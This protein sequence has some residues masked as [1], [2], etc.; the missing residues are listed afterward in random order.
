MVIVQ[1]PTSSNSEIKDF[2]YQFLRLGDEGFWC[3]EIL[4]PPSIHSPIDT[5]IERILSRSRL[6]DC[7]DSFAKLIGYESRESLLGK[8]PNQIPHFRDILD[9]DVLRNFIKS[10]YR[11]IFEKSLPSSDGYLSKHI[12]NSAYGILNRETITHICGS[13]VNL[14]N[15]KEIQFT[16]EKT[17]EFEKLISSISRSFISMNKDSLDS[18]IDKCLHQLGDFT[19]VD[20]SYVFLLSEDKTK[21]SNT[22]E[23]CRQGISSH[24][25]E[26]KD[27]NYNVSLSHTWNCIVEKNVYWA[28]S[29]E[30]MSSMTQEEMN[31][32]Y[33]QGIQSILLVGIRKDGSLLGFVG[34]DS[35][36]QT[37]KWNEDD[38]SM[39][40]IFSD[41]LSFSI[42]NHYFQE[43]LIKKEESLSDFYD[44]ISFDLEIAKETQKNLVS[45][46]FPKS[47]VYQLTS[48]FR[49]F[50]KVGGDI[51]S[52]HS[53]DDYIDILFGDVSGH[54]I[55]SAMVSGMVILSFRN[56]SRLKETPSEVL[57]SMNRD[58]RTVVL[59]H[60][61]SAVC[62]R[63]YPA[64]HK[65]IYSYAGHPPLVLIRNSE[66]IELQGMNTP[67]L[68]IENIHYFE[69]ELILL[70]DDRIVFYSD[71][72]YEVF[73]IQK[74]F[75]GLYNYLEILKDES[76]IKDSSRFIQNSILKVLNF[77]AGDIRDDLTMLILDVK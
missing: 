50:E 7:N 48:F 37:K 34:F 24:I 4:D 18:T 51:I 10:N 63:Y 74:E 65:I 33:T 25:H 35:V 47:E 39:L 59:N 70:K 38:F 9:Q 71:G 60:H 53:H 45:L 15:T 28:D 56:S 1:T 57:S 13:L 62:V 11:W 12:Q 58:L 36:I 22:H 46:D 76:T 17:L 30:N 75:L 6:V 5:Q 52:Y 40:N 54:G 23:W 41:I 20:R 21:I 2:I 29:I 67:L 19:G 61:I 55:S 27:I 64:E 14:T 68:T 73:S 3:F 44:R 69:N 72:C 43:E 16:L 26:M 49:P 31:L 32:I 8:N 42:Q 77:C 66:I